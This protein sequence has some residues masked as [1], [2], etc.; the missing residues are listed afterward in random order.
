MCS[1]S[2]NNAKKS[3]N[4]SDLNKKLK[5]YINFK[6]HPKF[7]FFALS[8][9]MGTFTKTERKFRVLKIFDPKKKIMSGT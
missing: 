4:F 9:K 1:S 2:V 3:L 5:K 6:N 7:D 8:L